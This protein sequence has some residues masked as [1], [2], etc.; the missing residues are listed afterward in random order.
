MPLVRIDVVKGRTTLEKRAIMDAVRKSLI[1]ALKVPASAVTVKL[2]VSDREFFD[3][4]EGRS[5][6]YVVI[7]MTMF[8]GRPKKA[9]KSLYAAIVENLGKD[10]GIAP[11]D[12]EIVIVES[13]KE[14]WGIR[15]GKPADEVEVGYDIN[16]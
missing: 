14:N 3:V 15:G 7:E 5:D 11:E 10:A 4:P 6:K 13:P 8:A 16:V 9:K 1:D 12:V 2:D